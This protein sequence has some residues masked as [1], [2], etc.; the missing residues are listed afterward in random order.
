MCRGDGKELFFLSN[1]A[2]LMAT[3]IVESS[4]GFQAEIPH[5][6]FHASI[7]ASARR[8]YAVT[9]DGKRF[10][11]IVPRSADANSTP[12]PLTVVVNW[13]KGLKQGR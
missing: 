9:K 3:T 10:L 13:I 5:E 2:T 4:N 12:Q 1:D 6:L 8:Q 11:M 7:S